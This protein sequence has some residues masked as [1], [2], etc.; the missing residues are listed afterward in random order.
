MT[1]SLSAA[2]K[3]AG[4]S[5]TTLTRAIK[6]GK[7]S[8]TRHEDGSYSID[9]AELSRVYP[10]R[11]VAQGRSGA[12]RDPHVTPD[13]TPYVD[14]ETEQLRLKVEMLEKMLARE[15]ETV[16]DLRGRL[17]KAETRISALLP[18]DQPKR[19]WP[20]QR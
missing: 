4:K 3:Q 11:Q 2:A 1:L 9:P 19:R 8:A 20:W 10:L 17:D 6:S 18:S 5:K 14:P 7:L 13:A 15:Q 12:V 16:D